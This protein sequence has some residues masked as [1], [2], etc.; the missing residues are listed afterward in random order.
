MGDYT[1]IEPETL[2]EQ[3]RRALGI[4]SLFPRME[5]ETPTIRGAAIIV[6]RTVRDL[7]PEVDSQTLGNLYMELGANLHGVL[8]EMGIAALFA[9]TSPGI[10]WVA[11]LYAYA[12]VLLWFEDEVLA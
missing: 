12:G 10:D 3:A 6:A 2:D 5:E 7:H 1:K 8:H 9:R 4:K 11:K